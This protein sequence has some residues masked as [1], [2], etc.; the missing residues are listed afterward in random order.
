M[1]TFP[2][3]GFAYSTR[4]TIARFTIYFN[5]LLFYTLQIMWS[6]A[7]AQS[8]THSPPSTPN[9]PP[10]NPRLTRALRRCSIIIN[11]AQRRNS[12]AFEPYINRYNAILQGLSAPIEQGHVEHVGLGTVAGIERLTEEVEMMLRGEYVGGVKEVNDEILMRGRREYDG[13]AKVKGEERKD[14]GR[15]CICM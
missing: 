11:I 9:L 4:T 7:A 1:I 5:P 2:T 3:S 13:G 14:K 10:T 8:P 6:K 12:P 15:K